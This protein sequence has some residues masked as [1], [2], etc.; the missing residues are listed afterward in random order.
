MSLSRSPQILLRTL[1]VYLDG[2]AVGGYAVIDVEE[3]VQIAL[4]RRN[5]S[6][7]EKQVLYIRLV[8]GASFRLPKYIRM[9]LPAV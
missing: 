2:R 5:P 4:Q 9:S 7:C 8:E 6:G 3:S 1:Q